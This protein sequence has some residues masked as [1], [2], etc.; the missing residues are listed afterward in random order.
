[1]LNE[2]SKVKSVLIL[3]LLIFHL[4]FANTYFDNI[5][6]SIEVALFL[7]FSLALFKSKFKAIEILLI[8]WFIISTFISYFLNSI[9]VFLLSTKV[10]GLAI[11]TLLYFSR[12]FIN[13]N[14]I[15]YIFYL[16]TFLFLYHYYLNQSYWNSFP[17]NLFYYFTMNNWKTYETYGGARPT[18]FFLA[19]HPS[20]W[21]SAIYLTYLAYSYKISGSVLVR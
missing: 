7:I 10:M 13:P 16:S 17:G 11:V 18:G 9:E 2:V 12:N 8:L 19:T 4:F 1:M 14:L 15:K 5:Q 20:A 3:T 21:F 6:I